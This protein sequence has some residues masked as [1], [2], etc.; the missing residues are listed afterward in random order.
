[1]ERRT[2]SICL[3][4]GLILTG[5]AGSEADTIYLNDGKQYTGT[6]ENENDY[7][8]IIQ[9]DR[10]GRRFFMKSDIQRVEKDGVVP[11][12]ANTAVE[13]SP[14]LVSPQ[15]ADLIRRLLQVNGSLDSLQKI[16]ASMIR[17]APATNQDRMKEVLG[18][19]D[20]VERL[21]PVYAQ[22]YTESDLK[23][24]IVF[25]SSPVGRKHLQNTPILVEKALGMASEYFKERLQ[26]LEDEGL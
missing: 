23:E 19:G 3:A 13:S 1:M 24:L 18:T 21:I 6:I 7:R 14:G 25:Y 17:E 16:F 11:A 9:T 10:E 4:V 26:T 15:K 2:W 22:Y 8:I 12:V 5:A 20:L